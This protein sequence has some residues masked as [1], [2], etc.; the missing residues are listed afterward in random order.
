MLIAFPLQQL[1][2]ERASV[3]RYTYI[4]CLVYFYSYETYA[5]M[6]AALCSRNLY[7]FAI[8][9]LRI[10][11]LIYCIILCRYRGGVVGKALRY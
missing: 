6:M 3:L 7:L 11:V 10:C 2:H 5:L 1:L 9:I 8:T 4:A